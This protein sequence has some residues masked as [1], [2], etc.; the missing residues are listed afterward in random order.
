MIAAATPAARISFLL[1]ETSC[2]KKAFHQLK[3]GSSG[4]HRKLL[5]HRQE[6]R[7]KERNAESMI[8]EIRVNYYLTQSAP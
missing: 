1:I 4:A 5:S 3:V 2:P 7:L 6:R 8:S